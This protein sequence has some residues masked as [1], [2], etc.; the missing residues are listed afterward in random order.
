M[1]IE[2][3]QRAIAEAD[4]VSSEIGNSLCGCIGYV[5]SLPSAEEQAY[6][7]SVLREIWSPPG[8]DP[9]EAIVHAIGRSVAWKGG[10]RPAEFQRS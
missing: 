5:D 8:D 10:K 2:A 3:K 4:K 1:K 9:V 7:V 6:A